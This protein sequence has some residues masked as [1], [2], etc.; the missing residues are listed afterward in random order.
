MPVLRSGFGTFHP[1]NPGTRERTPTA[2]R[3]ATAERETQRAL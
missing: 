1:H 2:T 3:N